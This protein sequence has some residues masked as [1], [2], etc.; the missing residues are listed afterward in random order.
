M[1]VRAGRV[2]RQVVPHVALSVG[3][4]SAI[5]PGPEGPTADWPFDA[6]VAD[7]FPGRGPLAG[8][9]SG[10]IWGESEYLLVA[11]CDMPDLSSGTLEKL[12]VAATSTDA[13]AVVAEHDGRLIAVLGCFRANL[14]AD[15]AAILTDPRAN[16]SVEAFVRSLP[17]WSAVRLPRSE[18]RNVNEAH[19]ARDIA[20]QTER[21]KR[22]S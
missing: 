8:I 15:A 16:T 21:G 17:R 22:R 12:L 6:D 20:T 18:L 11:P 14:A 13:Q 4:V 19:D 3:A 9:H 5:D 10:M 7:I 1:R 2:L